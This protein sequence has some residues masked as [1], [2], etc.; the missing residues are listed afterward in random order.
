M[1]GTTVYTKSYYAKEIA[2]RQADL[3]RKK[4][5]VISYKAAGNM[6]SANACKQEV[7]RLKAVI[8][9]LKAKMKAAPKG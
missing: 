6:G 2:N 7:E 5:D 9:G 8:E 1:G 4:A 3:A